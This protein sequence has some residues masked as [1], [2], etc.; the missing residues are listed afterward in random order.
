M[1]KLFTLLAAVLVFGACSKNNEEA[2]P[3]ANSWKLGSTTYTVGFSHRVVTSG[4]TPSTLFLFAD[5]TPVGTDPTV[6]SI[7]PSFKTIPTAS[8]TYKLVRVGAATAAN[9][10]ELSAGGDSQAFAYNELTAVDVQVTVS[11]G[12]LSFKIPEVNM[13]NTDGSKPNATIS[14][15]ITEL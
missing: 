12:K 15:E 11:S 4:G 5:K 2:K 10:F 13:M 14:G 1:K 6:H 3:A 7:V 9:E 8:G